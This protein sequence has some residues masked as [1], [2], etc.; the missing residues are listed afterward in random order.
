[1]KYQS[2][3]NIQMNIFNNLSITTHLLQRSNRKKL[4]VSIFINLISTR[5]CFSWLK[6]TKLTFIKDLY[7]NV[8]RNLCRNSCQTVL[9]LIIM[10]QNRLAFKKSR[11][12]ILLKILMI[13]Q[14]IQSWSRMNLNIHQVQVATIC[15]TELTEN[16]WQLES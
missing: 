2:F 9:F 7:L 3:Q 1:M 13:Y 16:W 14:F 12:E 15:I 5:K 11:T 6:I 10:I 4:T 8:T